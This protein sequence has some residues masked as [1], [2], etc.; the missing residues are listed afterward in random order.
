MNIYFCLSTKVPQYSLPGK[1]KFSILSIILF[2][3]FD[4]NN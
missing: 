4:S 3:I 1:D 2:Y